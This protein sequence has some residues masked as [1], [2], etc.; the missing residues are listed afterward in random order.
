VRPSQPA[1]DRQP[2]K[3]GRSPT[4]ELIVRIVRAPDAADPAQALQNCVAAIGDLLIA[5]WLANNAPVIAGKN[6]TLSR[7][8]PNTPRPNTTDGGQAA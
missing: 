1:A 3:A 4:R 5:E 8:G 7:T 6:L 2:P